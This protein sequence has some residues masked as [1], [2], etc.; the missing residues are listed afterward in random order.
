LLE[1]PDAGLKF[2]IIGGCRQQHT[3]APHP[4]LLRACRERPCHRA[5]EE[6][7]KRASSHDIASRS[8]E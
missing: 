2:R 3:D 1:C 4:L 7:D 8:F 6:G 5:A